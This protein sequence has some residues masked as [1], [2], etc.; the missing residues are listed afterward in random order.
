MDYSSAI[1][2][3]A[4]R[5]PWASSPQHDRSTFPQAN[6]HDV[7]STNSLSHQPPAPDGDDEHY[8]ENSQLPAQNNQYPSQQHQPQSYDNSTRSEPQRYHHARPQHP[9][10]QPSHQQQPP[11]NYQQQQQQQQQQPQQP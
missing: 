8:D 6:N 10:Q 11:Q 3:D 5:D 2:N 9:P 1:A 7:P 4:G